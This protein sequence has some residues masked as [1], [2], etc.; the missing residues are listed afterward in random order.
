M[1]GCRG[2]EREWMRV[3]KCFRFGSSEGLVCM[4][5]LCR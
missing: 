3:R 5:G 2:G 4:L 1:G